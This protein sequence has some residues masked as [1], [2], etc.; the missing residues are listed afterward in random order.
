MR[1]GRRPSRGIFLIAAT[2]FVCT[3]VSVA[4]VGAAPAEILAA[5]GEFLFA[6]APFRQSQGETAGFTNPEGSG[7]IHNVYSTSRGPD[8]R[9]LFFSETIRP[10]S[11]SEVAGTQYLKSGSYPFVCTLHPGMDGILEVTSEG[12]PLPRPFLKTALTVQSLKSVVRKGAIRVSL[13]SPTGVQAGRVTV[14]IGPRT[15]ATVRSITLAAGTRRL[16]TVKLS[17]TGRGVLKG[18]KSAA[19]SATASVDFGKPSISRKVLR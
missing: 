16:V 5:E 8:R 17:P 2:A 14:K 18:R 3:F 1:P 19:I 4:P 11:A 9:E 12:A 6:G 13:S 10:G 7:A 15:I